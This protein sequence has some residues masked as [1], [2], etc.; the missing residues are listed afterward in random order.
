VNS[1]VRPRFALSGLICSFVALSAFA[2]QD[3]ASL[4][5][6]AIQGSQAENIVSQPARPIMVRVVDRNDRPVPDATVVFSAPR[7][8]PG[9]DFADG[10]NSVIVFTNPQGIAVAPEYRANSDEGSYHI[11]IRAA[12]MSQIATISLMQRNIVPSRS[13]RKFALIAALAGGAAAAAFL[14]KGRGA[15]QNPSSPQPVSGS[16]PRIVFTGASVSGSK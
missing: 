7:S 16:L 8:G 11:Q 12:Y 1:D 14:T 10:S 6:L 15:K 2:A 4:R 9:G 5:L 13:S 3:G